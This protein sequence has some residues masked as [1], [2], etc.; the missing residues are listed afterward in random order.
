MVKHLANYSTKWL[1]VYRLQQVL[2]ISKEYHDAHFCV[3]AC[4][5]LLSY[6]FLNYVNELSKKTAE[7]IYLKKKYSGI[8]E[9]EKKRK[10]KKYIL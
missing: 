10:Q 7:T 9:S 8:S 5:C 2:R 4:L 1:M 3:N 6:S